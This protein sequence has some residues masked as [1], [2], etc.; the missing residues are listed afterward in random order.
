MVVQQVVHL[1][2]KLDVLINQVSCREVGDPI[3]RR[4]PGSEVVDTIGLAQIVFVAASE[5]TR[6][7]DKTEIQ[8]KRLGRLYVRE[9]LQR[10][11]GRQGNDVSWL[12][13]NHSIHSQR[14]AERGVVRAI[15]SAVQGFRTLVRGA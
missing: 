2:K 14:A 5:G 10:V 3:A 15:A 13:L 1:P 6:Y 9:C 8:R 11:V 4:S 12:D 7:S